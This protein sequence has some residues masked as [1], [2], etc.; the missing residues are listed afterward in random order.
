MY[1]SCVLRKKNV[2]Q[3]VEIIIHH[4]P[5]KV[6][7]RKCLRRKEDKLGGEQKWKKVRIPA[8]VQKDTGEANV[9][10]MTV[11]WRE[12]VTEKPRRQGKKDRKAG[13]LILRMTVIFLTSLC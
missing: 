12:F 13:T 6:R 1:L 7:Q 3:A 9:P 10:A 8:S 11:S 2:G 4:G 5:P